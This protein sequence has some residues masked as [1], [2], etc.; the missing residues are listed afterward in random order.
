MKRILAA[1]LAAALAALAALTPAAVAEKAVDLT[2]RGT[3][4]TAVLYDSTGGLPTSEANA[5]VQSEEGFIWIGNYSGLIRYDGNTFYRYPSSTGV[6]SVMCLYVDSRNRLWVGTNDSGAAML[7]GEDFTFYDRDAGL[8]SLSVR[9]IT[10]DAAGNILIGTTMGLGYID[11]NGGAHPINDPQIDAEYIC[12]LVAGSNGVI[13]GV[14]N[15]G[16]VFTVENRRVTGYYQPEDMGM[17][18]VNAVYPD[19]DREGYVFLGT[20]ESEVYHGNLGANMAGGERIDISPLFNVNNIR[21]YGGR[22][23]LCADNGI[24]FLND[25][26][27]VALQNLPMTNSIDRMLVDHE[28]NLWFCSSRQGVMKIVE[29]RFTDVFEQAKLD[30]LVVNTTCKVGGDLYIGTDTG[31]LVLDEHSK[32]RQTALT[33]QLEGVRIRCIRQ[34]AA[35]RVWL[36]TYSDN[37]LVCYDVKTDAITR[38]DTE[39]GM[40]ANRVRTVM[41]LADGTMA[42]ATNAGLNLIRDGRVAATYGTRQGISNLEILCLEQA[43]DGRLYLGSDGDGIYVVDG[44]KVSRIGQEDGLPSEVILRMVKDPVEEDLFW[45]ITSNA[46]AYMRNEKVTTVRNFPYSNNFDLFFD[47]HERM[48]VLSSNG[49]YVAKRE[50]VLGGGTIDYT[51]FDTSCGLPCV[52]TANSFS[53]LDPD[54]TLYIA[55]TAGVSSVNV[56]ADTDSGADVRLA[57]PFLMA[58]DRYIPV[59]ST[60]EVH[61]PADCRRLTI[62]A[63]AFTYSLNNPHLEYCLEGFDQTP[64]TLTK[65]DMGEISYTNLDGGTYRFRLS[66]IDTMTGRASRSLSVTLVKDKAFYEFWW[67]RAAVVILALALVGLVF[68]AI[69]RRKTQALLRKQKEHKQMINEMASAFAKCIDIKDAYT[70]GHSFRVAKYTAMLARQLGKSEEEVEEIYNIALLHDI[71]K[72]SIPNEILNKPGRL[73]DDEFAVMKTHSPKG[74]EI[75]KDITIAPDLALGAG[76]HHERI[77]GKGYPSGLKGDEIPEVA[78]IIAVADTFDAMYSTRPYRKQLPLEKVVAEIERCAGTQLSARVVE[79]FL[80]LAKEGAFDSPETAGQP[81]CPPV[82]A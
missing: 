61:I 57:V 22:V 69:A 23:W 24:G 64:V 44:Q 72:I 50:A 60:G 18:S 35:G 59:P 8:R 47:A 70:N 55:S 41:E 53:H 74:Q 76:Y 63:Y 81:P 46:L 26:K 33:R 45:I 13:Y 73:D 32:P 3:G 4:Y 29:N 54:G 34:D 17:G 62:N 77:D 27:C 37:A 1:V 51:L 58:D 67:F 5:I 82:E 49:V 15:S 42:V 52:A 6:A 75:L 11:R 48:W 10:E 80:Q 79:A 21:C 14:T 65:R 20:Q 36:C 43:A 2:G 9:A 71:G 12:E 78:Q 56:N 28:E 68:W 7:E 38:F 66:V 31:L 39:K 30:P 19:P 40:T 16:G 25:G